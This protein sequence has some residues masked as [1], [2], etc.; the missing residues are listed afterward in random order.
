MSSANGQ[1]GS[2][3]PT[4]W[5]APEI[6]KAG[7][8]V[9][10]V[11]DKEPTIEGS[12]YGATDD[13]SEIA[14]WIEDGR[15]HHDVAIATGVFGR[16]VAIDAD[17]PEKFEEMKAKYGPP[18][19]TTKRGGH[20]LFLH[21]RNGKVTST[22]IAP[23]L[24]RKGDGGI[25]VVPPSKGR[26]WTNGI[27][28][29]EDLP[30]LP[31]EFWSKTKGP[32][33][34][35]RT[36]DQ[37]RKD[38]AVEAIAK[39]VKGIK[40]NAEAGSRHEHLVHLCGV[41]LGRGVSLVD[42]EDILKAAWGAVG[43]DLSE[44][45]DS[46]I[47]NTLA[48]TQQAIREGRATGV[49]S[50]EKITPGLFDELAAAL[51][52]IRKIHF[53]GKKPHNDSTDS[54][55]SDS[56]EL[57]ELPDP[58]R[59]PV[60]IFPPSAAR[61]VRE[62]A[63]AIGCPDDFLAVG[64]LAGL[65]TAIGDTRKILIKRG[66]TE[67]AAV[68]AM[69]VGDPASKKSPALYEAMRPILMRQMALKAAHDRLMEEYEAALARCDKDDEKP[70]KPVL[71]RTYVDDIT[72]EKLA[73]TL[74][75]NP[76]G[77]VLMKDEISGWLGSMDQ[78]KAGGKGGDRQKWLQIHTNR[79][80]SVDRKSSNEPVIIPRPFVSIFGGIQP[81]VLPAFGKDRGDGLL[82]RFV[83]AYPAPMVGR[84]TDDEISDEAR[85]G[86]KA[87]IDA[88]YRLEPAEHE[89]DEFASTV[90]MSAEGKAVFVR[91]Y[92]RLH[93][94]LET[95]GFPRRLRPVYG[96]LEG[97][98]ARFALILAMARRAEDTGVGAMELVGREDVEGAA[99]LL[100]YFKNHARRVYTGL[101]AD[102]TVD[103]LGGDIRS[104]LID[105]ENIWEGTASELHSSFESEYKPARPEDLA[106][107]LR[108][109]ARRTPLLHFEDLKRTGTRRAFRLT[110]ENAVIADIA[111][112]PSS[113]GGGESNPDLSSASS[114]NRPPGVAND[115][116]GLFDNPPEWLRTQMRIC[117]EA[118]APERLLEPL[119]AAV[120]S[121]LFG[122][123]E[124]REEIM[125]AVEAQFHP[126][127]CECE[128]CV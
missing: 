97:Y 102:S 100:N 85:E 91:E 5:A 53:G 27:P 113:P 88:L 76:R 59:F 61:L 123:P 19:Y 104:F 8:K 109:I 47:P 81:E 94:E 57:R 115:V 63:A 117:R 46:E 34:G 62:G 99:A 60:E 50:M 21:P 13:L 45:L 18:T 111:V 84:W 114:V 125:P 66:W 43:G 73:D 44:R 30:I 23:G 86:Y 10:P 4:F 55:D 38:A 126:L 12:F 124:R 29:V 116:L 32:T 93:V 35:E 7:Y 58:E 31:Q 28:R 89:G 75:E 1:Q 49:P 128:V 52:W 78:Y 42:A 20:W 39:H 26:G 106:K 92:D 110:L 54:N 48:S 87:L 118:G 120:A 6:A 14:A 70:K 79:P 40:P 90:A 69:I 65:S 25:A 103:R 127:G 108:A 98:L 37:E 56:R 101:Y 95:P 36:T 9:F 122:D 68:Y 41:L 71:G 15:G 64:V 119:A 72:V 77:V 33:P 112:T 22:K 3:A 107:S 16:V 2:A 121:S 11:K 96:K 80:I 83:A 82:D 67:G 105:K 74:N 17:T 51:G 24:D